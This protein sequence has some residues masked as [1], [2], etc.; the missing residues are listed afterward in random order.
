MSRLSLLPRRED[1]WE[2]FLRRNN[3]RKHKET[4]RGR[5]RQIEESERT[6]KWKNQRYVGGRGGGEGADSGGRKRIRWLAFL[7]LFKGLAL[8]RVSLNK[9]SLNFK[10]PRLQQN[11]SIAAL[12]LNQR[13]LCRA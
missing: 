10:N 13:R 6:R 5:E 12:Y 4:K 1:E 9:L 8:P 11:R 3:K 7:P 2:V